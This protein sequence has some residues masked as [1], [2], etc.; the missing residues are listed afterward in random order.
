MLSR[1]LLVVVALATTATSFFFLGMF[2]A[3]TDDAF[4]MASYEAKM[5]AIRAE[6]RGA[7]VWAKYADRYPAATTGESLATDNAKV[8]KLVEEV[9]Q[10]LQNEMGLLAVQLLRERRSSS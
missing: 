8:S 1:R 10:E 5:I 6:I 4:A 3:R 7:V 9:K 2:Y